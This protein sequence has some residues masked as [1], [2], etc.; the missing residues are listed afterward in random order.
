[1]LDRPADDVAAG[2]LRVPIRRSCRLD[3]VPRALADFAAPHVGE[4]AIAVA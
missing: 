3:E 4:L 1:V 2:R